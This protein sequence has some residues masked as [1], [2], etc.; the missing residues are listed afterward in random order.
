ML[1]PSLKGFMSVITVWPSQAS[2]L[3]LYMVDGS[4]YGLWFPQAKSGTGISAQAWKGKGPGDTGKEGP[5]DLY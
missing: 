4:G 3:K 5:T 1:M 2:V